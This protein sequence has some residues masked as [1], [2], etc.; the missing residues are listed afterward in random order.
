MIKQCVR[1]DRARTRPAA[2]AAVLFLAL[3]GGCG[4]LTSGGFGEVEVVLIPDA[5]EGLAEAARMALSTGPQA[6]FPMAATGPVSDVP[7]ASEG[8][9]A[10]EGEAIEGILTVWVRSFVRR[11]DQDWE[12]LTDGFQQ[13]TLSLQ[14]PEPA[15]VARRSLPEGSYEA[16]RTVFTRVH[17]QVIRGLDVNG[18]PVTGLIRV[19][20]GPE[21]T[22]T[23][24]DPVSIEVREREV[25]RLAL[26]MQSRVWL[27]LVD[28]VQ[29]R[30]AGDEFR[31]VFRVRVRPRG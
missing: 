15:E 23:V 4:N 30:V 8:P 3:V 9:A 20:L 5:V 12:E 21:G 11:G 31:Q 24:V 17:A 16:V 6:V 25:V 13:L 18:E 7:A 26:E 28:A 10:T 14:D 29:R 27:R 1:G 19:D 2:T 22:L